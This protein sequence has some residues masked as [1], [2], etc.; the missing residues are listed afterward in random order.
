MA[1][2][3][4]GFFDLV[5]EIQ[6]IFSSIVSYLI[7]LR[8]CRKRFSCV[9]T[10]VRRLTDVRLAIDARLLRSS[11]IFL[12]FVEILVQFY[13]HVFQ[14]LEEVWIIRETW[15]TPTRKRVMY[16]CIETQGSKF[17]YEG[18]QIRNDRTPNSLR[19]YIS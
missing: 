13:G 14:E 15:S 2:I 7:C 16:A 12:K 17:E 19:K 6:R 3:H 1:R 8:I 9:G 5:C 10:R 4:L 18:N 11:Q